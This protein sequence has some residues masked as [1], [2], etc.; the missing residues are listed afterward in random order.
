M[1]GAPLR[2]GLLSIDAEVMIEGAIQPPVRNLSR[3][4]S[5]GN[6]LINQQTAEY[7]GHRT[8]SSLCYGAGLRGH[9]ECYL[10][11]DGS[12]LGRPRNLRVFP[13][14]LQRA[15]YRPGFFGKWHMGNDDSP[16]PGFDHWVAIPGQGERSTPH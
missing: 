5:A 16:R 12:R 13:L 8:Y 4:I 1:G 9:T 10:K 14:A 15:G 3:E 11:V 6:S 2:I 7:R